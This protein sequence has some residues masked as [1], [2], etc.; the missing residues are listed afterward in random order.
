MKSLAIVN[1]VS[2]KPMDS[3]KRLLAKYGGPPLNHKTTGAG[4]F[5]HC[6]QY[7]QKQG[8]CYITTT[9]TFMQLFIVHLLYGTTL[10]KSF[11]CSRDQMKWTRILSVHEPC[12]FFIDP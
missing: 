9:I 3:F 5:F 12:Q 7:I 1:I 8:Q 11:K 4:V 2:M 10:T 6:V